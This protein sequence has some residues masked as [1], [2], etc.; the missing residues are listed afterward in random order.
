MNK[1]GNSWLEHLTKVGA[2]TAEFP[3]LSAV[4]EGVDPHH[5]G[6]IEIFLRAKKTWR[7]EWPGVKRQ[8]NLI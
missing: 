1:S 3:Q 5:L 7:S 6:E 8:T 2:S 4:H